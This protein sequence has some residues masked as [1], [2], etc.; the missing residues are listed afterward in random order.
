MPGRHEESYPH[1]IPVARVASV[2]CP[3]L[4]A[5]LRLRVSRLVKGAPVPCRCHETYV[6]RACSPLLEGQRG[7]NVVTSRA[8]ASAVS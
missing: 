2:Q 3:G 5:R 4:R 6:A 7:F 1:G 8:S